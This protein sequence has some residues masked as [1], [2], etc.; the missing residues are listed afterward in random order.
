[1]WTGTSASWV[2]LHPNG[3]S[4]AYGVRNGQQVG[5]IP[6]GTGQTAAA[7]WQG[8]PGS[9]VNLN[10]S[11]AGFS[12]AY[13]TDGASQVGQVSFAGGF[14]GATIW[15]GSPAAWTELTEGSVAYGVDNGQQVGRVDLPQI[16]AALWT[17]SAA[18]L[19][20]LNPAGAGSSE[21]FGVH[22]GQQVGRAQFVTSH[23]SMWTGSAASWVDLNPSVADHGRALAV[24]D[25]TQV[26]WVSGGDLLGT[27]ASL[28][29]GSA[30]SWVNLS[31]FLPDEYIHDST[32][33]VQAYA[34]GVWKDGGLTY[35]SGYAWNW[36]GTGAVRDEAIMW[37]YNPVPEPGTIVVLGLGVASLVRSRRKSRS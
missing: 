3:D 25:G 12:H 10:P 24:F 32:G 34:T 33:A 36:D 15:Q 4:I 13:A 1:M 21:A 14:S 7:L 27:H 8:T 26:G 23:A 16:H 37:V 2:N 30:A 18:S 19:V 29:N 6:F 17:G 28:W 11:G 22:N 31:N 35:I 9:L 5:D 20:D